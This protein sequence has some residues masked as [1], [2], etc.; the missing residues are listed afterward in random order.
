MSHHGRTP[1]IPGKH[2]GENP[3]MATG[4][5]AERAARNE[6]V[7]RRANERIEQRLDDLSL[8]DGRS[9]FLC[10]CDDPLC[11]H[12]VRLTAAEYEAVRAHPTRFLVV[13][14]HQ[15]AHADTVGRHDQYDVIEKHGTAG[16]I[17]A[18]LDPRSDGAGP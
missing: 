7:F 14:G 12:P 11:T 10:E 1:G 4:L 2:A 9:P 8:A 13:S 6:A 5:S 3:L 18:A 15:A 16:D 17:A